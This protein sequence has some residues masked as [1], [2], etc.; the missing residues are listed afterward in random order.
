MYRSKEE[1]NNVDQL[2]YNIYMDYG[3]RKFPVSAEE[4]CKKMGLKIALYKTCY[5]K[6][7]SMVSFT[8]KLVQST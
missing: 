1:Y 3:I 4:L 8:V 7:Q 5:V 2:I 6:S